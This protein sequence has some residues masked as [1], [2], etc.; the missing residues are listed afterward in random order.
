MGWARPLPQPKLRKRD[1]DYGARAKEQVFGLLTCA[2]KVLRASKRP[3]AAASWSGDRSAQQSETHIELRVKVWSLLLAVASHCPPTVG[4]VWGRQGKLLPHI[5]LSHQPL[6]GWRAT[7]CT[8]HWS[9]AVCGEGA[10]TISLT[11]WGAVFTSNRF[12]SNTYCPGPGS[13]SSK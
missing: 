6:S 8:A 2:I 12:S 3:W 13:D 10:Q 4:G 1:A 7:E 5:R 11:L 9:S